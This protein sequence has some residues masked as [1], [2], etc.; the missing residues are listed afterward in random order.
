M[1]VGS[2]PAGINSHSSFSELLARLLPY[3][4]KVST[5]KITLQYLCPLSVNLDIFPGARQSKLKYCSRNKVVKCH[6]EESTSQE[7]AGSSHHLQDDRGGGR[8]PFVVT[9]ESVLKRIP[10]SADEDQ[11]AA[12]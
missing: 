1:R 4:K 5:L 2:Y 10:A 12:S 8:R 3:K 7:V 9:R 11:A 6:K